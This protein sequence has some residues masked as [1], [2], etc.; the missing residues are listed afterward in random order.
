MLNHRLAGNHR[1]RLSRQPSGGVPGGYDGK[2]V[3]SFGVSHKNILFSSFHPNLSMRKL[4]RLKAPPDKP[5]KGMAKIRESPQP[6]IPG[7]YPICKVCNLALALEIASDTLP[8]VIRSA[9][10]PAIGS[11]R[12]QFEKPRHAA[13]I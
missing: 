2:Y 8:A 11:A 1:Q 3:L 7:L 6:A 9:A 13:K 10:A 5:I 4:R 12:G